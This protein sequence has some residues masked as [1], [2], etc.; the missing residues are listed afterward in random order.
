M[1]R[2]AWQQRMTGLHP[3]RQASPSPRFRTTPRIDTRCRASR[4]RNRST[5]CRNASRQW[6]RRERPSTKMSAA[7]PSRR[8]RARRHTEGVLQRSPHGD[9]PCLGR[10]SA[11]HGRTTSPSG[12]PWPRRSGPAPRTRT[13][14]AQLHCVGSCPWL[15][16]RRA[17]GQERKGALA[18]DVP[19]SWRAPRPQRV[20]P[21]PRRVMPCC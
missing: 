7:N 11:R 2:D 16:P 15:D 21:A 6:G 20:T 9:R 1:K 4:P 5:A 13:A 14:A 19:Q 12:P 17:K 10:R 8:S 3:N 18:R